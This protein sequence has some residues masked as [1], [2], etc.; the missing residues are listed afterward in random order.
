LL[1]QISNFVRLAGAAEKRR[2]LGYS[3][4]D[5]LLPADVGSYLFCFG[6][7]GGTSHIEELKVTEQDGIPEDEFVRIA[8]AIYDETLSIERSLQH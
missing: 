4:D 7:N 3:K 2:E 1:H 6:K 5:Y 8:E